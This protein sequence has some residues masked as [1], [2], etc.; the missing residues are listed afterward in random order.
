M[1]ND[2]EISYQSWKEGDSLSVGESIWR[3]LSKPKR[4]EWAKRIL[5]T[6]AGGCSISC[7]PL[8]RLLVL[9]DSKD[10]LGTAKLIFSSLRKKLLEIEAIPHP[11]KLDELFLC[12]LYVAENVA[13]VLYNESEPFDSF[14]D[15]VGPWVVKCARDCVPFLD[16]GS[17]VIVW[18]MISNI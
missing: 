2:K 3:S 10:Q 5:A 9:E 17:D 15:D 11:S 8:E 18:E 12:V 6:I 13:K 4:V 7:D 1:M 14:D 16:T